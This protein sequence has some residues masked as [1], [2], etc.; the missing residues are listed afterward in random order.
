MMYGA[1]N[2]ALARPK[3]AEAF[4]AWEQAAGRFVRAEMA[5]HVIIMGQVPGRAFQIDTGIIDLTGS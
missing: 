3:D 5:V 4:G 1:M 2:S